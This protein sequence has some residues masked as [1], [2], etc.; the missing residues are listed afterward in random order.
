MQHVQVLIRPGHTTQCKNGL[1]A[2]ATH[3]TTWVRRHVL[4]NE[5]SLI[6]CT[7]YPRL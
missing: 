7:W 1:V 3:T 6:F 2:L 4:L 5:T